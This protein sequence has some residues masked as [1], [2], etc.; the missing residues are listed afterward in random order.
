MRDKYIKIVKNAGFAVKIVSEDKTIS[1][2]QYGG[3]PLESLKI[4]AKK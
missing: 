2:K 3:I 1:K 4:E